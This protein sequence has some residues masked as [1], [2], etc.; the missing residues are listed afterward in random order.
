ME[1][2]GAEWARAP[3][4][5]CNCGRRHEAGPARSLPV[6]WGDGAARGLRRRRQRPDPRPS[7]PQRAERGRGRGLGGGAA[8][9]G[10]GAGPRGPGRG[11][12]RRGRWVR[13]GRRG[14]GWGGRGPRAARS[15]CCLAR[16]LTRWCPRAIVKS[17]GLKGL[18]LEGQRP[19]GVSAGGAAAGGVSA[20]GAAAAPDSLVLRWVLVRTE[21]SGFRAGGPR[22]AGAPWVRVPVASGGWYCARWGPGCPPGGREGGS[23]STRRRPEASPR[24]VLEHGVRRMK[25][26][27]CEAMC[28]L[29]NFL[30]S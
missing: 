2:S 26:R 18:Q 25:F 10:P 15:G 20:G 27:S 21:P 9:L 11:R 4:P 17:L 12:R 19:E 3:G 5:G 22:L 7:G 30:C 23:A 16:R 29:K 1:P 13:P 6:A 14:R 28:L 8:G 24:L